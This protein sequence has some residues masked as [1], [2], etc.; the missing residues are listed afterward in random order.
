M[1]LAVANV[2]S[3]VPALMKPKDQKKRSKVV[4]LSQLKLYQAAFPAFYTHFKVLQ[5]RMWHISDVVYQK[6]QSEFQKW[7]DLHFALVLKIP[8]QEH[9]REVSEE[10]TGLD[11]GEEGEEKT[12]GTVRMPLRSCNSLTN[13]FLFGMLS[14]D[15]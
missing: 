8:I 4:V 11:H 5:P 15:I 14:Y 6:L 1:V 3:A 13:I 10:G 9:E 12:T 7:K 2:G